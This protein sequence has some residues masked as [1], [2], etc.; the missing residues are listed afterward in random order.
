MLALVQGVTTEEGGTMALSSPC[1]ACSTSSCLFLIP[2]VQVSLVRG[3][4]AKQHLAIGAALRP[5]RE[6]N[7]LI[8][9]SGASF[10]NMMYFFSSGGTKK[11]G[12]GHA[13]AWAGWLQKTVTDPA[14]SAEDRMATLANWHKAPSAYDCQ[15]RGRA[16][17]LMP[18]FVIAGTALGQQGTAVGEKYNSMMGLKIN[19]FEWTN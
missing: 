5:L 1:S 15:P 3:Q 9:G 13:T 7:V 16:E 4:D 14:L 10:H 19:Q 2:V 11:V 8:V 12:Q 6:R 17:H 18:L